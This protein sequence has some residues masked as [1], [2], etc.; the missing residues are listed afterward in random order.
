MLAMIPWWALTR[1]TSWDSPKKPTLVYF[2]LELT[3]PFTT[4]NCSNA[5]TL[6]NLG[7]YFHKR[8]THIEVLLSALRKRY[9]DV[10]TGAGL[11]LPYAVLVSIAGTSAPYRRYS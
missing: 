7:Q 1:I 9:D 11:D 6:H 2:Q 8:R 4:A 3:K 10:L 5:K